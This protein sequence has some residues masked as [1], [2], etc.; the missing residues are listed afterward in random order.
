[1]NT[2]VW[3]VDGNIEKKYNPGLGVDDGLQCLIPFPLLVHNTC[4]IVRKPLDGVVFF[5]V[6]EKESVH[7]RIRKKNECND[8]PDDGYGA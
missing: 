8:G 5:M 6:A 4:P 1:M 7:G 2:S 3:N